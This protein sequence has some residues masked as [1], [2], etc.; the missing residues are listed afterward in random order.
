MRQF[1]GTSGYSYKEWKGSFYPK[2]FSDKK[3]LPYYGER[4]S[5][6]E[7][8]YTFR[9]IPTLSIVGNWAAAVPENFRF[10][11][12]APEEITHRKRL[13]GVGD[14]MAR[15]TEAIGPLGDRLGPIFFQLPPHAKKDAPR[16]R[17]FLETCPAGLRM[18]F[19]FRHASWF[20]DE[21]FDALRDHNSALCIADAD[22]KLQ[23]PFEPTA[24]W[25]YLRLRRPDYDDAALRT[26]G[27]RVSEQSWDETFVFFKHEEEGKGPRMATRYLELWA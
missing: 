16:L 6:V 24:D 27:D 20:D 15:L 19:E 12:K 14:L 3:M 13:E 11:M 26:W 17:A 23:V 8:N 10:V 9:Q 2:P 18:A 4:F 1:V 7:I 25:G 21:V 22:D 5:T